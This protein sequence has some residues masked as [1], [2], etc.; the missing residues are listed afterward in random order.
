VVRIT[1]ELAP[2]SFR[3]ITLRTLPADPHTVDVSEAERIVSGG[4][5]VGGPEGVAQLQH[6]ADLLG[7]A[8]GG[9]RVIADRGWLPV[10]RYIGTTGKIVAP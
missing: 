7:A 10:E 8:L 3:D 1:P 2:N 5:G 9:T 4:L 6:L